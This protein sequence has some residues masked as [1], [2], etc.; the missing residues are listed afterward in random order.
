[1]PTPSAAEIQY[2]LS[3][4]KEDRAQDIVISHIICIIIALVAVAL[5]L[6]SRRLCK[7]AILADDYVCFAALV[8]PVPV[9]VLAV[10]SARPYCISIANMPFYLLGLCLGR[11]DR[12]LDVYD[13]FRPGDGSV[14]SLIPFCVRRSLWRRQ[15]CHS[16]QEPGNVR[17]GMRT[18]AVSF[19]AVSTHI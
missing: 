8:S 5:R 15:A 16:S 2:Q 11:G 10:N 4:I 9:V 1:M 13:A 7:A 12:R 18:R 19:H 6:A 3:H 17:Q 14:L